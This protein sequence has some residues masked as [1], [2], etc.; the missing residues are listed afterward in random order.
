MSPPSRPIPYR[1]CVRCGHPTRADRL[2]HGH[3][4][5]CATMLGLTGGTVDVGQTGP[6]LFD[7][8]DEDGGVTDRTGNG[9]DSAAETP[10]RQPEGAG[11]G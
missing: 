4:P 11:A 10:T 5:T 1:R 9:P 8:A 2:I 3:G 6:D 7:A